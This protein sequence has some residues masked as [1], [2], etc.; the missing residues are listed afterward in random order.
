MELEKR[1]VLFILVI[2][3]M[4]SFLYCF[5]PQNFRE[6]IIDYIIIG[7]SAV[8]NGFYLLGGYAHV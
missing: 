3:F 4:L 1:I 8:D 7:Y 6:T 2:L 5:G